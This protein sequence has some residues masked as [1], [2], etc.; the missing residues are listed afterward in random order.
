MDVDL[1]PNHVIS[2]D[3]SDSLKRIAWAYGVCKKGTI[4]ER[5]LEDL[6]INK[7]LDVIKKQQET[8]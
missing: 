1:P 2:I 7:V 3:I 8:T 5:K 6:L 4:A